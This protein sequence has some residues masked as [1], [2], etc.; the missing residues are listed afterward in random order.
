VDKMKKANLA[1]ETVNKYVKY[2]KQ[3]VA[4]LKDGATGE[5]IHHLQ[6]GQ[7][8]AGLACRQ[9]EGAVRRSRR[10]PSTN[11]RTKRQLWA[12]SGFAVETHDSGE[13]RYVRGK[14]QRNR[15]RI[16]VRGLRHHYNRDLKN[17]FKG[18][19]VSASTRPG[20]IHNICVALVA[21]GM[22]PDDGPSHPHTKDCRH[23]FNHVEERRELRPPLEPLWRT[24][25]SLSGFSRVV[26]AQVL[27]SSVRG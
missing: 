27:Q 22:R 21:K 11:F 8:G 6:V 17:L 20:P 16:T 24:G 19:A 14:L 7:C 23:H 9:S 25:L 18:A 10:K 5:P 3:V 26:V 2:V 1:A 12:Y 15:E 4:S 13:Y